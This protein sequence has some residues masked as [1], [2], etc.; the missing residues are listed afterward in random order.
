MIEIILSALRPVREACRGV[1][2]VSRLVTLT[3]DDGIGA[4]PPSYK[5]DR[6]VYYVKPEFST[7]GARKRASLESGADPPVLLDIR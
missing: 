6:R 4:S 3:L 1:S 5:A 2:G 7:D